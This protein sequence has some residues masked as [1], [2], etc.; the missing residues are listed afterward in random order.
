MDVVKLEVAE[1][2]FLGI[3]TIEALLKI[4]AEGFMFVRHAYLRS[5][6]NILDFIVIV[7]GYLDLIGQ[8]TDFSLLDVKALR[9]FR[10]VRPL[11]FLSGFPSLQ[12]VLNSVIRAMFPLFNVFMLVLFVIILYAVI[13]LEFLSGKL[14]YACFDN[15]TGE[16]IDSHSCSPSGDGFTCNKEQNQVCLQK[17]GGPNHGITGFDN[18]GVSMLTVF[19][20][21]TM[22]GWTQVM[23]MVQD[24][25][26]SKWPWVYFTT[27][28]VVGSFFVVN[29]VLGVLSG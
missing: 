12:V 27:L 26:G 14:R 9:A 8:L 13:G 17:W 29:L 25:A 5:I 21:I 11:K 20:C 6:W 16:L 2:V 4:V 3:F 22:E 19:Q 7:L 18:I 24:S 10:V 23:Y 15:T 28:V 1:W